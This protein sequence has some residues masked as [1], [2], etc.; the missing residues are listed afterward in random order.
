MSV[1]DVNLLNI[2][3]MGIAAAIAWERPFELFFFAYG[4][5]GPLHYLTEISWLKE[6]SWFATSR[7]DWVLPSAASVVLT[8]LYAFK[9]APALTDQ[10]LTRWFGVAADGGP[11]ID[12]TIADLLL[13]AV[14]G[15]SLAAAFGR[16][17][18]ARAAFGLVGAALVMGGV[19][20]GWGKFLFSIFLSTLVHVFFFTWC[21]MLYG[22]LKTRSVSG[23][24]ACAAHLGFGALLLW[25]PDDGTSVGVAQ[26]A[27]DQLGSFQ[28]VV[29]ATSAAL[30]RPNPS[31]GG[32]PSPA[33]REPF[34]DGLRFMAYAYT[35]H[36]LNWFSK[37][38]I[39][40]W[41]EASR[42]RLAFIGAVW[43]ASLALYAYDWKSAFVA[44]LA[45]SLAHV[46][47]EFPLNWR[48]FVGIGAELRA[49]VAGGPRAAAVAADQEPAA[50][51]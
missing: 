12:G 16:G 33:W 32:P 37:T 28:V 9:E 45:L 29:N 25:A 10:S 4:V 20:A 2:L 17:G 35:Y 26:Q 51:R 3:L 11:R 46:Y 22:A 47:L 42:R 5:L 18:R 49:R 44:L 38:G 40:R 30:G 50:T 39:I 24:V 7:R 13:A 19:Q 34:V 31:Q 8:A 27:L 21:F 15:A 48:T 36:Y 41:H 23:Y 6:R 43:A 1:R 14:V